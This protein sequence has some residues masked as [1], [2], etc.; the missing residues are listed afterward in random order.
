MYVVLRRQHRRR[1]RG[2]LRIGYCDADRSSSGALPG[3]NPSQTWPCPVPKSRMSCAIN[4]PPPSCLK[5]DIVLLAV[6]A[7]DATHFTP[8]YGIEAGLTTVLRSLAAAR[9][10]VRVVLT[11]SP[12]VGTVRRFAQPLRWVAGLETDRGEPKRRGRPSKTPGTDGSM[13]CLLPSPAKP[14]R[15]LLRTPACLPPTVSTRTNAAMPPWA[16]D[17]GCDPG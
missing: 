13:S 15:F 10:G 1:A 12:A 4:Y 17:P 14:V 9:P 2:G 16:A 8:G 11:G 7:N 5:P 3:H 6:G